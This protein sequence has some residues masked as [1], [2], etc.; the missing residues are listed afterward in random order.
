MTTKKSAVAALAVT[1]IMAA[2]GENRAKAEA[3]K[4]LEQAEAE[5]DNNQYDKAL[6]TIDSLRKVYPNAIE[7]RKKRS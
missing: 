4:L 1:A 7:T 2:C 3:D 5:F 6:A